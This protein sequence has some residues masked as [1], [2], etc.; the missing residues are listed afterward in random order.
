MSY[1][2]LKK[3]IPQLKKLMH[4]QLFVGV[5]GEEGGNLS[6]IAH[7]L[8][9]GAHIK[10]INS[11]YLTIPSEHVP[12]GKSAKDYDNLHLR[13][14]GNGKGILVDDSGQVMFYLVKEV[15][16]PPRHY[17]TE[18]Y[19]KRFNAWTKEYRNQIHEIVMGRQTAEG[20]MH[21]MGN[22]VVADIRK[23][24]IGWKTPHN[25]PAT[26]ARKHGVDNPLVDTGRLA[27]SIIYEVRKF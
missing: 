4:L 13:T 9:F 24:I 20:C 2:N 17:F 14:R 3:G 26:K 22:I 8:E 15:I 12:R 11:K 19:D 21:H 18:T 5:L 25:A 23:A 7:V 10:P 1:N 27:Q 16:I 6:M